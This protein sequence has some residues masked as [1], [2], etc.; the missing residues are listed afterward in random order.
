[1]KNEIKE[2]NTRYFIGVEYEGGIKP[3]V[4]PKIDQ[5]WQDFL[6]EDIKLLQH[7]NTLDHFIG[8]ECYPPDFKTSYELDYYAMIET[9]EHVELPGF[10]SKKLPSGTYIC[11]VIEF[12][13]IATEIQACYKY[14]KHNQIRVH[15]GFDYEDYISGQDYTKPGAR[16]HFCLLLED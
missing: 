14:V 16:L 10:V 5:L 11:F 15:Y 4:K 12:D 13:D 8:L 3:N 2:Y 7:I 9:P 6:G 1:M